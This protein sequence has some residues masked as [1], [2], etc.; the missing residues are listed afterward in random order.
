MKEIFEKAVE[1]GWDKKRAHVSDSW[2]EVGMDSTHKALLDPL[3]WQ[4]LSKSLEWENKQH[5][6]CLLTLMTEYDST[7]LDLVGKRIHVWQY[8]WHRFIDHLA[9]DKDPELF[10][11]GLIKKETV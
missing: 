7:N 11:E 9:Q 1:G 3:F 8:H 4:G 10:F 2:T 6:H 5:P